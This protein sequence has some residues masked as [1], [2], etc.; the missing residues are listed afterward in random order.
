M[1]ITPDKCMTDVQIDLRTDY[2]TTFVRI[3]MCIGENT[4]RMSFGIKSANVDE[5][6]RFGPEAQEP[7][8]LVIADKSICFLVDNYS[9][10]TG[11]YARAQTLAENIW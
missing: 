10:L 2:F 6:G 7:N 5:A 9:I 11:I 3:C 1:I 4:F 8:N